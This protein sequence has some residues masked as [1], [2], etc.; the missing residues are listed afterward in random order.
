MKKFLFSA[1]LTTL[2][3]LL[4]INILVG[5]N[6]SAKW[7]MKANNL[8]ASTGR[9]LIDNPKGSNW[10]IYFYSMPANKYISSG[11]NL[12][13]KGQFVL[14]P[15][16]YK[17]TINN[18]PVENVQI[19]KGYDTKLETG[20]LDISANATWYLYDETGKNSYTSGSKSEK[21]LLPVGIYKITLNNAPIENVQ[22]NKGL[23]TK[24][25]T[26]VLDITD[27]DVWYLYDE[28]GTT[29][30]T[31]GNKPEKLA[32]PA[33]TY[34]LKTGGSQRKVV[35]EEEKVNTNQEKIIETDQWIIYPLDH[36][37]TEIDQAYLTDPND[38]SNCIKLPVVSG[39][40]LK[41]AG[42]LYLDNPDK[43]SIT[44]YLIESL[45]MG[46]RWFD[47]LYCANN[48]NDCQCPKSYPLPPGKYNIRMGGVWLQGVPILAGHETKIKTGIVK[49]QTAQYRP[50]GIYDPSKDSN[51]RFHSGSNYIMTASIPVGQYLIFDNEMYRPLGLKD[52]QVVEVHPVEHIKERVDSP[53]VVYPFIKPKT[54]TDSDSGRLN[55][56]FD[57]AYTWAFRWFIYGPGTSYMDVASNQY[58]PSEP[59][60][61]PP[62]SKM[63]VASK[64]T[65]AIN[66]ALLESVPI[67]P[68]K[69]TKIKVGYLHI[70]TPHPWKLR[71]A[72]S[73]NTQLLASGQ[74][75]A[76]NGEPATK[77]ILP[78]GVYTLEVETR[79]IFFIIIR[80]GKT[81][82]W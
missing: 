22:I 69:E 82:V 3:F 39:S 7:E 44:I 59:D 48:F 14:S 30:Y 12:N 52:G 40:A 81:V 68:G 53:W 61:V 43:W 26:G 5:Q 2:L 15:G 77:F 20:I 35:V 4:Q 36:P 51:Y 49:V 65:F 50:W 19:K 58:H 28:T 45:A 31:S 33:G 18:T 23:D 74:V 75:L 11:N 10:T 16:D 21:L 70:T 57:T 54:K 41:T 24:L 63:F 38:N 73:W 25:K 13:N 64:Y 1:A 56:A 27:N 72:R 17:I 62:R 55:L 67:Q 9:L 34:T 79:G 66:Q 80:N 29:S 78:V 32:I 42:S 46:G 8:K 37:L 76:T 71:N 60:Y 47:H 6:D